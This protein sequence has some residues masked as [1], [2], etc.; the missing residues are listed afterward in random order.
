[1]DEHGIVTASRTLASIDR[2]NQLFLGTNS[3]N[4]KISTRLLLGFGVLIAMTLLMVLLGVYAVT[5]LGSRLDIIVH[6]NYKDHGD[7]GYPRD[8]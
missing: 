4:L 5:S 2:R 3:M 1:M 8:G 7:R 6:G